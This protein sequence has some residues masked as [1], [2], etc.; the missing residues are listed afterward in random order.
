MK[1]DWKYIVYL[2]IAFGLFVAVKLME[3]KQY[4]WNPTYAA[5]DKNPFGGYIL[6]ELITDL[7]KDK[8]VDVSN[9]T[10]YELK[11][12]L[13]PGDNLIIL[14]HYFR[15]DKEDTQVM[16][17]HVEKGGHVFIGAESFYGKLSDT[18]KLDTYDY[19]FHAGLQNQRRDTSYLSF[20]NGRLDS[21]HHYQFKRDNIHN[22]FGSFDTTRTTIIAKNDRHQPVTIRIRWGKGSFIFTCAPLAFSNIYALRRDN[23]EFLAITLSHLPEANVKWTEYYSVGRLEAST[24]L[25]FILTHPPL[26]WAYYVTVLALLLFMIFEAKR[27][28]RIIPII[29]PLQNT[30]LEFIGTIGN[31]YYQRSDH[32]NIA[33]KKILF[34]LEMV[35]SRYLL[36]PAVNA[37]TFVSQLARKTGKA[38]ETVRRLFMQIDLIRGKASITKEELI[39]LNKTIEA[40]TTPEKK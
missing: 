21:S 29:P 3:P 16:L 9:L 26:A 23:H 32:K 10:V 4:D 12:S 6:N 40:F 33:E 8:K 37:D 11:D 15:T 24:P 14:A 25:R 13:K 39:E 17:D 19:L 7:F 38:E 36:S 27:K 5:E 35:R 1:R 2:S 34:F 20:A 28:Q 22:Y 30:S 18:L 31:L